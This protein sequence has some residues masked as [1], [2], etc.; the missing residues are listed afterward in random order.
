[1]KLTKDEWFRTGKWMGVCLIGLA[2]AWAAH[3]QAVSTTTVQGTVY[4]ANGVPGSGTLQLSWP[5]F[6]TANNQTVTAGRTTVTIGADGFVSV[7]LAPNLGSTPAGLFYTAVFYMSDGTTSTE[8][9]VV[10]AAAQASIAQIRSQVMPAAQAL[11][12]VNK[13]YVDQAI[14]SISQSALAPS[15]GTLTGPLYLS[16]DPTQAMQAA[17]K[18]Y[19]DLTFA[20][21]VPLTG[22]SLTGPFTAVQL[23]AAYQVDQFPGADFGAKL[24]ACLA[25]L[26]QTYGGTCDARNFTGSQ[27]MASSL[28]IST[29]NATVM[30]PCATISTAN[31]VIVTAG[32]RNVALRGCALRGASTASGSQGGTVFMYSGTGA[33]VKVG[34]PTYAADTMG[35]HLDNVVIN[36]TAASNSTAQGLVAY[37][38][39]EM[40]LQSLYFLGNSDQTGMTLDGTG[41]YTGGTFYD[42]A[43][44]GFQTAINTIGHQVSNAATTD[45]LNASTFVRLHINCPTSGGNPVS[46]TYGINLQQGDGNTFTGGDVEGCST[47]LH[48]GPNAQNNTIV[49]LRNENSTSQVVAD[50]HS[51]YNNWITG[52]TMFTGKLTDNGTRNSFLDTF[53]RTF[54]G[55]NGDWYG[56]LQDATVTNH[57]RLGT[58]MGNE[59]GL[60]DEYQTDYGYRWTKGFS[61][62]TSGEQFYNIYDNLGG[63]N[64]LSI[65]QYLSATANVVTNVVINNGGCYTSSTPPAVS[66]S[67]GGGSGAAG[68][69]VMGTSTSCAYQVL[70][71][72]MTN[73]GSGYTSQPAVAFAGAN[74]TT[75]PSAVAEIATSGSTNNQS[76]LNSSGTGAVVFNG[77]SNSG[78]GGVVFG[79]GGP[80]ETTVATIN[81]A[82]NAQFSGTLQVSGT[83][84]FTGS[85]TV[86]NQ[87]DAEIDAI[88][89]AG[90]TASQ[91]ESYIYKDYTG[92]SQWYMVKDGSNNWAVNSATGGLDSFK[93]YQSTNSG[94]TYVNASNATGVVRVNYET[95]S[96]TQFKVYGGASSSIYAA[97]TGTTSIQFPGLAASSGHYCLQVDNSG[98]I[99][100]TGATCGTGNTN[101]TINSGAA[102]QIAYYGGTGTALNGISTIPITAGGTGASTATGA[103]A[104]LGGASL[105]TTSPQ[106]FAGPLT[107]PAVT[108]SVAKV[109]L[110]TAP[111]YNAKCDGVTNDQAAIQA[112]FNDA[113]A[114][115]ESVQF[116]AGTCKTG[117]ITIKGQPFFGAGMSQTIILGEPGQD[118]FATPDNASAVLLPYAY[119]HDLTIEVDSSVN[120]ASSAVGGN[121]SFPNRI[122]GTAGGTTPLSA[123]AG[124]PPAPGPVVINPALVQNCGFYVND[125]TYS[126][127]LSTA[128]ASC[129]AFTGS[130]SALVVGAPIVINGAGV[131]GATLTTTIASIVNG[132]SVTLATPASTAVSNQTG[133]WGTGIQ[134]PWYFGNCGIAFPASDGALMATAFNGWIFRNLK[135]TAINGPAIASNYTCGMFEQ[136]GSYAIK[137]DNMVV[138]ALWG[139][140]V[141]ALPAIDNTS[142]GSYTPDTNSYSNIDLQMNMIPMVWYNGQYRHA[143][144]LNIYSEYPFAYGLMQFGVPTG[145][146]WFNYGG[147]EIHEY[148]DECLST[149]SGEHARFTTNGAQTDNISGGALMQ[150]GGPSYV[151]WMAD[152]S[153]TDIAIGGALQIGSSTTPGLAN[154]NKF[155]HTGLNGYSKVTDY[156]WD[157]SVDSSSYGRRYYANQPVPQDPVG[158]LDGGFIL[159]GNSAAP[160]VSGSDLLTTCRDWSNGTGTG[161]NWACTSDPND[162]GNIAKSYVHTTGT[163]GFGQNNA[164]WNFLMQI[165]TRIPLTSVY[166]ETMARCDGATTC[167]SALTLRDITAAVTLGT[168]TVSYGSSWTLQG[169]PSSSNPCLVNLSSVPAGDIFGFYF[170]T[171][172]GAGLTGTDLAFT[173]FEPVDADAITETVSSPQFQQFVQAGA[174]GTVSMNATNWKWG[175]AVTSVDTSSPVGYS[176]SIANNYTLTSANGSTNLN[177]GAL[178]PAVVSTV[179]YSVQ[180]PPVI[181]DTLGAAQAAGDSTLTIATATTSAWPTGGCLLVGQEVECYSGALTVGTNVITVTRGQYGT[182]PQA[183]SSGTTYYSLG[184]GVFYLACN[185]TNYAVTNV[186][187]GPA[188]TY[189]SSPFP[190]QSCS[191]YPSTF[192]LSYANGPTGQTYKVSSVQIAQ[193]SS[194]SLPSGANQ[195]PLSAGT[196]PSTWSSTKSITGSGAAIPTGPTTSTNGGVVLYSGTSGQQQDSTKTLAGSGAAIPTGPTTSTNGG[197]VLYSGTSGQQ[198]DST[199]TLA[200]SGAAVPTGPTAST[201]GDIVTFTGTTGQ[202]QDSGKLLTAITPLAG[203]TGSI[204][205]SALAAGACTSG[206]V[207]I[208]G[209]TTSMAVTAT[210]ATYPGD[211][212]AWRPYVSAAG[213]VTVKVCADVAG[214]PT[215]SAYNVRVIQ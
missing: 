190:G 177:G 109:L 81:N 140:I 56:S 94:D 178:Y 38:T 18:H 189:F 34:D 28:T 164:S 180:A 213:T 1:M 195:V 52:G 157:N 30:L 193:Q 196:N 156:G 92:A 187:F 78:T 174:S 36:I 3:A 26:S 118:V 76:V 185:A 210:P 172:T 48:L 50:A 146:T 203:T 148:Y 154:L 114:N 198:Q 101:G 65:G 208:A 95:G 31:Q 99:T 145:S 13:A 113:L 21:A 158:K 19:V 204:G 214:T 170:N 93:A 44:N 8:Y 70:S 58:G 17:D 69:A 168:C 63:V 22:A 33:M 160:F 175:S 151:Y 134:A 96:G 205:G 179:T 200:G 73:N 12:A 153:T 111:P 40:D 161:S 166:V 139:G 144:N 173:A 147:A 51:S 129:A 61:D 25:A 132:T 89:W 188:W 75:A 126:T 167:S 67:G 60:Q 74:Q 110:V 150:C 27:S 35:F 77:S 9:W 49:G 209:A 46:G 184:T 149:N 82:G 86:R 106:N 2:F 57:L 59:R 102:G 64:R 137:Y 98:Y 181:T 201:S 83:S 104:T 143:T 176:T 194:L 14:A 207:S 62:G 169:G 136:A 119:V 43:F 127:S 105:T 152:Q 108:A 191:G 20:Q 212:M 122:S 131:A 128:Y 11:Q 79:S 39:Q 37:R 85:T 100:N 171:F 165:G 47:A 141:E 155:L 97:F 87:A 68:T 16:S 202:I 112:A 125:G 182:L 72:T 186:V 80:T 107:G 84:T 71:V 4:L 91:K 88:L 123:A 6:T 32:T 115:G 117:T 42:N 206:T 142:Y 23:G 211:G 197:V 133:T 103:L 159:S 135:I 66:F 5:A 130:P 124:G 199:K 15:G 215:A 45:W 138:R 120:A 29:A 162:P 183:H 116:P 121:N 7:N 163:T 24:Q 54:N 41:N 53:H 90:A 10:P 192:K 55:M